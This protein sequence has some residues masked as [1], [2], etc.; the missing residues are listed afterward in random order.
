MLVRRDLAL[1]RVSAVTPHVLPQLDGI[2][3]VAACCV[4]FAH[5]AFGITTDTAPYGVVHFI[6]MTAGLGLSVFFVL[7]GFVIHLNYRAEITQGGTLRY[8]LARFCAA[9]PA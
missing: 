1:D 9:L 8:G 6:H 3:F 7:S 2:R 5:S 4:L